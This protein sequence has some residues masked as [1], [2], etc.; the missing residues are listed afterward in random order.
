MEGTMSSDGM[1]VPVR[2]PNREDADD[3][4]AQKRFWTNL[5]AHYLEN[6]NDDVLSAIFENGKGINQDL[7]LAYREKVRV[8]IRK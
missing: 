2:S 7:L 3:S 8:A 4:D 1:H 6:L 5:K